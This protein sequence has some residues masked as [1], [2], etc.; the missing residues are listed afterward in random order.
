MSPT[1][2]PRDARIAALLADRFDVL[3]HLGRGGFATVYR[4]QNRTLNRVEA[5]KVLSADL[6]EPDFAERFRQ[7]ARLAASLDHPHIIKIFDFG[8]AE[9]IFW[10]TMQLVDGPTLNRELKQRGVWSEVESAK[11]AAD[12]LDA[13][14]YSHR[15]GII[16]RDM[17]PENILI[18]ED[19]RPFV[20]D[21]GI[22]KSEQSVVH[23][24]TGTILGSPAYIAPEQLTGGAVDGRADIY[25]LGATLY[26]MVSNSFP[27]QDSDPV[28]M[29]MKRF[30]MAPEPL[31]PK[32]PGIDP[33]FVAIVMKAL[34]R[35]P[36][37]RFSTA[38]EMAS[39]LRLFLAGKPVD[40]PFAPTVAMTSSPL[41]PGGT[42]RGFSAPFKSATASAASP[43]AAVDSASMPTIR[44]PRAPAR[45]PSVAES[46]EPAEAAPLPHPGRSRAPIWAA[47]AAVAVAAG[48]L[49]V[50]LRGGLGGT[51]SPAVPA[52]VSGSSTS[53]ARPREAPSPIPPTAVPVP[54]AAPVV[55]EEPPAKPTPKPERDVR[56]ARRDADK[57]ARPEPV[58]RP[59]DVPASAHRR[60]VVPAGIE[61]EAAIELPASVAREHGN[62]SV[63][64]AVIVG[65]DGSAKEVRVISP[66]CPEC[67]RAARAAVMRYRFRPAKDA[68]GKPVESRVAVPVIIPAPE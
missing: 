20:M 65:E 12:V 68:E 6:E 27:F 2:D 38:G 48:V 24:R 35:E 21:F 30:T 32:R 57:P 23:T 5:L 13:L 14:D 19:R 50:V 18:D 8:Q 61:S 36:A 41:E 11:L 54:T 29:A 40:L 3:G 46:V 28:R 26:R 52:P 7:E 64:L 44:T 55:V 63:G 25:S 66:V 31:E 60:A 62:Q 67:D 16:H 45:P 10:F 49:V 37:N 9:D 22:A 51:N 47:A 39:M 59:A 53:S 33:S 56:A 15:R 43:G 1:S 4:V 42:P 34:E 58:S 17:K